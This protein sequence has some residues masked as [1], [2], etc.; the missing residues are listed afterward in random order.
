MRNSHF[1][2]LANIVWNV[3]AISRLYATIGWKFRER[4][5]QVQNLPGPKKIITNL[6]HANGFG[7]WWYG[8]SQKMGH[9]FLGFGSF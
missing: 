4:L 2:K 9:I 5:T 6:L 3:A 7:I 1:L 8:I